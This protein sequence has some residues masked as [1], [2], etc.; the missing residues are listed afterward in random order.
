VRG[1]DFRGGNISDEHFDSEADTLK[2]IREA[3]GNDS[4][5]CGV[6]KKS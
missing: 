3:V 4:T 1:I 5:L 6:S 2:Y